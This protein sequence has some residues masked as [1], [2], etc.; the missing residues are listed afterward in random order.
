M[1]NQNQKMVNQNK[2]KSIKKVYED[3]KTSVCNSY[4][5]LHRKKTDDSIFYVGISSYNK[6]G[7]YYRANMKHNRSKLWNNIVN[8]YGYYIEIYKEN[9]TW[10]DACFYEKELIKKYGRIDNGS[11]KLSNHTIGGDG[12]VGLSEKTKMSISKKLKLAW[13]SGKFDSVKNKIYQ[14]NLDGKL[15]KSYIS[16][17]EAEKETG[18]HSQSIYDVLNNCRLSAGG[19]FWSRK[20]SIKAIPIKQS[21]NAIKIV[22]YNIYNQERYEFNSQEEADSYFGINGLSTSICKC[23]SGILEKANNIVWGKLGDDENKLLIKSKEIRLN[24]S[25][26][27]ISKDNSIKIYNTL[28]DACNDSNA[29]TRNVCACIHGRQKTAY[30][31]KWSRPKYNDIWS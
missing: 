24:T 5:Y 4:V 3:K 2:S 11:G 7:S 15:I 17:K 21:T 23:L 30:G 18:I 1:E 20:D 9:I 12:T 13:D 27:R 19:F 8:K 10:E 22:G 14:Y 25:V 31:F 16:A 28:S 6:D 26:K 29:D